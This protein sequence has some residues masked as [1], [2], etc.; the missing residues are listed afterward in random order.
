MYRT[1]FWCSEKIMRIFWSVASEHE[2]C[3]LV[4]TN[5]SRFL[6]DLLFLALSFIL[7]KVDEDKLFNLFSLY[8]NIIRIKVLKNKPDHALVQMADGF[9]A[10]FASHFLRV[11]FFTSIFYLTFHLE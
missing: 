5:G 8:G 1:I 4:H 9:Q 2:K 7:Q 10:E 3:V 6:F 11:T